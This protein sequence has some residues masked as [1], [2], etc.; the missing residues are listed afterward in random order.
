MKAEAVFDDIFEAML[1]RAVIE[2]LDREIDTL[3]D[4]VKREGPFAFSERHERRM[5]RL[6]AR[7]RRREAFTSLS[8]W[9]R[10]V[11]AVVLIA[12]TLLFGALMFVPEVRAAVVNTVVVWY[13][14]FTQFIFRSE[15][16]AA[17][18][19]HWE[20]T[21]LPEGYELS[22]SE[23]GEDVSYAD[24]VNLSTSDM[25]LFEYRAGSLS[26]SVNNEEMGYTKST[27]KGV[28]YHLFVADKPD[29]FNKLIWE[30]NGYRFN[31][32][33]MLGQDELL[34]IAESIQKINIE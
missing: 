1:R 16:S 29:D 24:Y 13:E 33:S 19:A 14:K 20:I 27:Y 23:F 28:Q 30:N 17:A 3:E 32:R 11:A 34:K 21:G 9:S 6:F 8:K 12:V 22:G 5:K 15:E 26:I 10:R 25:I 31:I 2:N 4:E 7:T 18:D